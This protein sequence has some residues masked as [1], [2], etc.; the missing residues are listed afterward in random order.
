MEV[1]VEQG[2]A[3]CTPIYR[4]FAYWLKT[5]TGNEHTFLN[6]L[7]SVERKIRRRTSSNTVSVKRLT[8][9]YMKF[10]SKPTTKNRD[11]FY[12]TYSIV[13]YIVTHGSCPVPTDP[14]LND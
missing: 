4:N 8:F 9:L 2:A 14:I 10:V 11:C 3:L 13:L 6:I 1:F 12:T 7:S 5:V